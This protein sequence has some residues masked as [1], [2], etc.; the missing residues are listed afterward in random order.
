MAENKRK[1]TSSN[2]AAE[3]AAEAP[4]EGVTLT[5]GEETVTAYKPST[6]TK[7]KSQG[8]KVAQETDK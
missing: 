1:N 6:V 4:A 2:E 3:S 8:W 5:R 7:L